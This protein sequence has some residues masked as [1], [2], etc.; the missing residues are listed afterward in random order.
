MPRTQVTHQGQAGRDRRNSPGAAAATEQHWEMGK[1][2]L[3]TSL[4][5]DVG[6]IE[7]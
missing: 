3:R 2:F 1:G 6:F 5:V 7:I 4:F